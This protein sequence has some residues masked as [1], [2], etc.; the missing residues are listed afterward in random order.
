MPTLKSSGVAPP[1]AALN[2]KLAIE[3]GRPRT[4]DTLPNAVSS[5]PSR[6]AAQRRTGVRLKASSN[7]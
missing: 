7:R 3:T 2:M 6:P 4:P 1:I 5:Q